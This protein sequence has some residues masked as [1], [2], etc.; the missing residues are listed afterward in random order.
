MKI[1]NSIKRSRRQLIIVSLLL[2][3][4]TSCSEKIIVVKDLVPI[5]SP[6]L[7]AKEWLKGQL[8][9]DTLTVMPHCMQFYLRE[10]KQ[11]RERKDALNN[12]E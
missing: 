10:L 5:P 6:S 12:Q 4:L 11:A 8:S 1:K 3:S 7:C 2:T 9:T